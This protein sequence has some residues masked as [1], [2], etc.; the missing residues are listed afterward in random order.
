VFVVFV[1]LV[2]TIYASFLFM[3]I[4]LLFMLTCRNLL[5]KTSLGGGFEKPII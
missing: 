3:N 2:G 5:V 1:E 4:I